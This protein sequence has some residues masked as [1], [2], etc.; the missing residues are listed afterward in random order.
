[1]PQINNFLVSSLLFAIISSEL[2]AGLFDL[3]YTVMILYSRFD[4]IREL[5]YILS[6]FDM[7]W[8]VFYIGI[9]YIF[10]VYPF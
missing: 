6:Y 3:Q 5:S 9:E 7:H 1:M 8:H 10:I 2:N 4:Q